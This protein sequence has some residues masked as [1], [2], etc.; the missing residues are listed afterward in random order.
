MPNVSIT[1]FLRYVRSISLVWM[2]T[3]VFL[4]LEFCCL[5]VYHFR[6]YDRD[7]IL[8]FATAMGGAFALFSFLKGIE[9]K[10][11]EFAQELIKSWSE[12]DMQSA[13][14]AIRRYAQGATGSEA[15]ARPAFDADVAVEA[16]K[17]TRDEIFAILNFF[18]RICLAIRL[19]SADEETLKRYYVTIIEKGYIGVE[20]FILSERGYLGDREAFREVQ[21]VVE[22]W[23]GIRRRDMP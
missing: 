13:I 22:K 11:R 14:K 18:E 12:P 3:G 23:T 10:R 19:K 9:E 16:D 17:A 6:W 4:L 20:P 8:F 7:S 5:W 21:L 15:Y 2:G 1:S